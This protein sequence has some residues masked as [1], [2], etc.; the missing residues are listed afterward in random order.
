M[1]LPG[2]ASAGVN[3]FTIANFHADYYLTKD[4]RGRASLRTVE[5]I[6]AEFPSY[7]QNHG[8]ERALPK[9]YDGHKTSL[10]IVSIKND[11]V[12]PWNFTTYPQG[13]YTVLRIGDADRY[14][15]GTQTY[16]ITYTQRDVTKYFTDTNDD[17]FYWD[18]TGTGWS[19]PI[20][21]VTATIHVD[22]SLASSLT[23][24]QSCAQGASGSTEQCVIATQQTAEGGKTITA[25]ATRPLAAGE[26]VSFAI[27]FTP[28]TFVPYQPTAFEKFMDTYAVLIMVVVF[29]ASLA[30]FIALVWVAWMYNRKKYRKAEIGPI[31]PEYIPPKDASVLVAANVLPSARGNPATAELI[32]L[33]VRHY[34]KLYQ[35]SEGG[36]FSI[37]GAEYEIEAVK[38]FDDLQPEERTYLNT[39]FRGKTRIAMKDLRR[40]YAVR[41]ELTK[42]SQALTNKLVQ[43]PYDMFEKSPSVARY[44]RRVAL[45][46]AIISLLTLSVFGIIAAIVAFVY[47][48]TFRGLTDKGLAL[49]R[50]LLGLQ[51]YI[52]L[53]ET[54][55]LRMLQSPEGAEKTGEY[56]S[57]QD[58]QQLVRLYERVLP[59]AV[60]FGEEKGWNK[61]LGRY[62]EEAQTQPDWYSGTRAFNAAVFTSAMSGFSQSARSYSASSGG[63]GGASAGGG[64]GGGGGGGW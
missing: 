25:S 12:E 36:F 61:Q 9:S 3:D 4:S 7:D 6:T 56:V 37:N 29:A 55:R 13:D 14:V 46:L 52:K 32:D 24:K 22:S 53:A 21:A 51:M 11:K 47:S 1:L 17:E 26:T 49:E 35:V 2:R 10:Q 57:G 28:H 41:T 39:L 48:F 59:Y 16:T 8:I 20:S 60:L 64:G 30:G 33:A 58:K 44:F 31:A 15:H 34:I 50:Y 38:P 54:D 45:L 23:G 40:N 5:T 63:S 18:I 62:Y 27:G 42:E 19:Q 43:A